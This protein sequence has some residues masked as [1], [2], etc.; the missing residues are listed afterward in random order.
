M[1]NLIFIFS[2]A[3]FAQTFN[4]TSPGGLAESCVALEK[5]PGAEELYSLAD[6]KKEQSYCSFDFYSE[7]IALCPKTW[8]TSPATMVYDI[9][10]SGFSQSDYEEKVCS[11]RRGHRKLVK[12][13]QTM[14]KSNTS[15]T[16]SMSSLLYYHFS[17]YFNFD[18]KVPVAVLRTMDKDEHL[19]RV[20]NKGVLA[21]AAN[22]RSSKIKNGWIH[23]QNA[24]LN[25]ES[26]RPTSELFTEDRQ[27]IYGALLRGKGERYGVEF[28]GIRGD[29]VDKTV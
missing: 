11:N 2:F 25:P 7:S 6:K 23:L 17:R 4:F 14:N 20:S 24:E 10:Q 27:Q 15:G 12:F 18:I 3:T 9:G 1:F 21:T 19:E 8:S 22:R 29:G 26:Y 5:M 28:N 16:F 13:K